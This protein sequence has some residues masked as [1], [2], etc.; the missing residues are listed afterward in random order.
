MKKL[1]LYSIAMLI[2]LCSAFFAETQEEPFIPYWEVDAQVEEKKCDQVVEVTE[3]SDI[4][5]ICWL[6]TNKVFAE[7]G[8][9]VE[10]MLLPAGCVA[11]VQYRLKQQ[12]DVYQDRNCAIL[13]QNKGVDYQIEKNPKIGA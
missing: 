13:F 7:D 9:T 8:I 10:F 4:R 12:L 6:D 3:P 1:M 5:T 2:F 11:I